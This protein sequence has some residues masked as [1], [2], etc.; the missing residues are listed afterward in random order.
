MLLENF[1]DKLLFA[2]YN[3]IFSSMIYTLFYFVITGL[4][5]FF[6]CMLLFPKEFDETVTFKSTIVF[7]LFLIVFWLIF[8]VIKFISIL[9]V[10]KYPDN[11]F[12]KQLL[13]K[14][15]LAGKKEKIKILSGFLLFDII[16]ASIFLLIDLFN[17]EKCN[18]FSQLFYGIELQGL[19]W[20]YSLGGVLPCYLFF[21]LWYK[22]MHK[23]KAVL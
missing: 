17:F 19:C 11:T 21:L 4:I 3:F 9:L 6:F 13:D 16:V 14:L 10:Y 8:I 5:S 23:N 15:A 22:L 20:L 18:L 12:F 7:F 1:K 2:L